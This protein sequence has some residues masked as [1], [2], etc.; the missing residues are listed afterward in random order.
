MSN[1]HLHD[2]YPLPM[3]VIGGC[4]RLRGGQHLRYPDRTPIS[5]VLLTVLRRSGVPL[6][7]FGDS[8]S[9]CAGL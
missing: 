1:S 6:E 7:S 5:N 3:A 8:T 4:G 2:H 9:E